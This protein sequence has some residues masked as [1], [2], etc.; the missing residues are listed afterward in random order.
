MRKSLLT[1]L[2][3]THPFSIQGIAAGGYSYKF[4]KSLFESH[5]LYLK[6]FNVEPSRTNQGDGTGV[7]SEEEI[8]QNCPGVR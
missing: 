8:D 7:A 2:N 3:W 4:E 5:R 6:H 1:V